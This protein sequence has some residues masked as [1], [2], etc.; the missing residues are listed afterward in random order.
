MPEVPHGKSNFLLKPLQC[1]VSLAPQLQQVRVDSTPSMVWV[2]WTFCK[3][4]LSQSIC[5]LLYGI[6]LPKAQGQFS[7]GFVQKWVTLWW[8]YKKQLKMAIYSGFSHEKWWF[9]IAMLVHQR[10]TMV[11]PPLPTDDHHFPQLRVE[12]S[13]SDANISMLAGEITKVFF[14]MFWIMRNPNFSG[15]NH[16]FLIVI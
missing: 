6:G 15:W 2:K 5:D 16:H 7:A 1:Q 9:S 4:C 10:V 8:T 13:M 3:R 14:F 11:N 12:I